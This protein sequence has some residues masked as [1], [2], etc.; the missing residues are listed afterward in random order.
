MNEIF[1]TIDSCRAC[2]SKNI[3]E[4]LDL[5]DQP[6]ANS[7]YEHNED[8]PPSVPLRLLVCEDCSTVQLGE[9]VDP[10]YLFQEYLWVTGTSST[11]TIY[12]HQFAKNALSKSD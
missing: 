1:E 3:T 11:A 5:G 4:V 10:K 6:P 9:T 8:R 7:L 12:S 2:Q